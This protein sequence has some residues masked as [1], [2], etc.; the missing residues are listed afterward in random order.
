MKAEE[1]EVEIDF[2]PEDAAHRNGQLDRSQVEDEDIA[3]ADQE[4]DKD[5][6]DFKIKIVMQEDHEL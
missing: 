6:G 3:W 1:V 2:V 5:L 4:A